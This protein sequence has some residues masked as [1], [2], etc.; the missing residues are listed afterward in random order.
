MK[1]EEV[2]LYMYRYR[3]SEANQL[4]LDR[5]G[6]PKQILMKEKLALLRNTFFEEK[7]K[8]TLCRCLDYKRKYALYV[9]GRMSSFKFKIYQ[10]Y[11]CYINR[12]VNSTFCSYY[13]NTLSI[14]KYRW[15][16]AE[17]TKQ[18]QRLISLTFSSISII[19]I[20]FFSFRKNHDR[21][22]FLCFLP[23][24]PLST[25]HACM[26]QFDCNNK[27]CEIKE[28]RRKNQNQAKKK[29]LLPDQRKCA[30][31]KQRTYLCMKVFVLMSSKIFGRVSIWRTGDS[32]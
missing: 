32:L 20:P 27:T 15:C 21:N 4:L 3:S 23:P 31:K 14:I 5:V 9:H 10:R 24:F 25:C 19:F 8:K 26:Q 12:P 11:I 22:W 6:I 28:K 2:L 13:V 29:L 7:I 1:E 18:V 30:K 16:N 17:P